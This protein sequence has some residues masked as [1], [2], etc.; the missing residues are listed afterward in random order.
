MEAPRRDIRPGKLAKC[1]PTTSVPT[2]VLV[3][4]SMRSAPSHLASTCA[5][6]CRRL[7]AAARLGRRYLRARRLIRQPAA[8][9]VLL[10]AAAAAGVVRLL[11]H[12]ARCGRGGLHG[13]RVERVG[14]RCFIKNSCN[15]VRDKINLDLLYKIFCYHAWYY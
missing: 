4:A 6:L 2:H 1:C 7:P 8:L 10:A 9:L 14:G 11:I 12:R 3:P 5:P 13:S 15:N